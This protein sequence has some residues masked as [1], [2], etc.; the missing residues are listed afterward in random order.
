MTRGKEVE[1]ALKRIHAA[2]RSS[3]EYM[4]R[5]TLVSDPGFP[6]GCDR[7]A[8]HTRKADT[9]KFCRAHRALPENLVPGALGGDQHPTHRVV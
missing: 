5:K 8:A 6:P 4:Q 2:P 1:L 7:G 3:I 9:S